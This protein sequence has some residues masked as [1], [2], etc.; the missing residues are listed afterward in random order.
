M[1]SLQHKIINKDSN[2]KYSGAEIY[3]LSVKQHIVLTA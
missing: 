2:G 1:N 3:K